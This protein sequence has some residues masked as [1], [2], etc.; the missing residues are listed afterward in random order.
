MIWP[1]NRYKEFSL[2]FYTVL[3]AHADDVQAVSVDEALIEATTSVARYKADHPDREDPAKDY[4]ELIRDMVRAATGCESTL[5]T[6]HDCSVSPILNP[7][8]HS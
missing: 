2:K 8:M 3:M 7:W 1:V 6:P 5:M 4:A